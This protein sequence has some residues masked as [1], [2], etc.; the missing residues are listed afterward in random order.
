MTKNT[1][2][3]GELKV[4]FRYTENLSVKPR[5]FRALVLVKI[6]F[7]KQIFSV[8]L[9]TFGAYIFEFHFR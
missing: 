7:G 6:V 4:S 1:R 9:D 2:F 8:N 3:L 5:Y